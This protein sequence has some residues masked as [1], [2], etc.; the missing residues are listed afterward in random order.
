MN[1][2]RG[3]WNLADDDTPVHSPVRLL[4][5]LSAYRAASAS[6][7]VSPSPSPQ[8]ERKST[9]LSE[10]SNFFTRLWRPTTTRENTPSPIL[11]ASQETN[12]SSFDQIP[13]PSPVIN[14]RSACLI[15]S[16]RLDRRMSFIREVSTK[17]P[18]PPSSF[19]SPPAPSPTMLKKQ[20]TTSSTITDP[21]LEDTTSEQPYDTT[22]EFHSQSFETNMDGSNPSRL[23][24]GSP[25]HQPE[26]TYDERQRR[27]ST[28]AK[29]ALLSSGQQISSLPMRIMGQYHRDSLGSPEANID[30]SMVSHS[31]RVDAHDDP[32]IFPLV[33]MQRRSR[34]LAQ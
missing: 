9:L 19:A 34:S 6:T 22:S 25:E 11:I 17:N 28:A 2:F 26:L 1:L 18:P 24:E 5:K 31:R 8:H 12:S 15:P 10:S 3:S 16:P 14:D 23:N 13:E 27:L 4:Q 20:L 33:D 7:P 30:V 32:K 21:S 29:S